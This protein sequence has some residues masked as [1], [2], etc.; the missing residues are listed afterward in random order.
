MKQFIPLIIVFCI[1][2]CFAN[3]QDSTLEHLPKKY[4]SQLEYK[5]RHFKKIP[6]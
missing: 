2:T 1:Y 4:L 5:Y 3:A 6:G